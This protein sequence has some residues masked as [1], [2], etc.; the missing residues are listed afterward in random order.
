VIRSISQSARVFMRTGW[1]RQLSTNKFL[2]FDLLLLVLVLG[3][4]LGRR[5]V[6]M[7]R[8]L[9]PLVGAAA[10]APRFVGSPQSHGWGLGLELG[11]MALGVLLG[12]AASALMRVSWDRQ[13]GSAYSHGGA[14]Y[15]ALWLAISVARY[16][17]AY[18]AQH[19]FAGALRHFMMIERVSSVAL[20][21]ALVA[22]FLTMYVTRSAALLVARRRL[23][24]TTA[25]RQDSESGRLTT[26]IGA[27]PDR[28]R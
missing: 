23:R 21:D 12:L 26:Q 1:K 8:V 2:I 3:S 24:P 19:W 13:A 11:G 18:G 22:V 16:V 9:R 10:I 27:S 6:T 7:M 5:K 15:A 17:F 14:S 25:C 20:T 4:D 28:A